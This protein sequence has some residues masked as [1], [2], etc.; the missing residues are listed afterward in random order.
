MSHDPYSPSRT[1]QEGR[2]RDAYRRRVAGSERTALGQ[3]PSEADIPKGGHRRGGCPA[4][5]KPHERPRK[6]RQV[7]RS[8]KRTRDDEGYLKVLRV[9]SRELCMQNRE[10]WSD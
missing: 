4:F 1:G 6:K 5:A 7:I 2:G 10:P 3:R 9:V 8:L